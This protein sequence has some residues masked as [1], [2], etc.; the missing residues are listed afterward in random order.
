[1]S[2][3]TEYVSDKNPHFLTVDELIQFNQAAMK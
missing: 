1:V 2:P 3:G